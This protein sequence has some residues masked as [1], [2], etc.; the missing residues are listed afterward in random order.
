M[1]YVVHRMV[2]RMSL[3]VTLCKRAEGWRGVVG[4]PSRNLVPRCLLVTVHRLPANDSYH[5]AKPRLPTARPPIVPP[6]TR[7]VHGWRAFVYKHGLA[8]PTTARSLLS[9]LYLI[10]CVLII[11]CIDLGRLEYRPLQI[12]PISLSDIY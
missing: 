7:R 9:L 4:Y 1:A 12:H 3:L 2:I 8:P 10:L 6:S 11:L 5:N